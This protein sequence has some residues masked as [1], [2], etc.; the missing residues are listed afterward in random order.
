MLPART[1]GNQAVPG[2]EGRMPYG[3]SPGCSPPPAFQSNLFC[4][5]RLGCGQAPGRKPSS[6]AARFASQYG[7]SRGCWGCGCRQACRDPAGH[8]TGSSPD[9]SWQAPPLGHSSPGNGLTGGDMGAGAGR[10]EGL[11]ARVPTHCLL[12]GQS[13]GGI[14]VRDPA[15]GNPSAPPAPG[16]PGHGPACPA[17]R[18]TLHQRQV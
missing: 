9:S 10:L 2:A 17:T 8:V 6:P 11:Q 1:A 3:T 16:S 4:F 12:V 13:G 5:T 14:M 7:P 18:D 15:L